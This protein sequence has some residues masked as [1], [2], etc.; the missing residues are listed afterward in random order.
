MENSGK[1]MLESAQGIIKKTAK[2]LHLTKDIVNRLI[3]PNYIHEFE[4]TVK[5]KGRPVIYK[6]FRIQ[7]NNTLG[8]YKGGIR[9]H[10]GVTKEEVQALATLMTIKCAVA[11]IPFGGGKGGVVVDPKKLTESEL[12][13]LSRAYARLIAPFIGPNVDVPAPDV[14]TNSKIMEWMVDE[15]IKTQI[16]NPNDQ[17]K[18]KSKKELE[19]LR[20]TFTGKLVGKGGTL[21]RTEATGRG[22]VIILKALLKKINVGTIF[23]SP[24]KWVNQD[25][26]LQKKIGGLTI[27]VQG[28]GNVGYYFA[29]IASEEGFKVV[30]VSDSHGAVY[31]KGGLSPEKTLQCKK[32]N[33]TVAGCYCKGSV[34]DLRY[35]K[36]ITNE[37]L[38]EL[39]VDVLVPSALENVINGENMRKIKAKIIVEMANGPLTDEAYEFLSKKGVIVVPD[40]LANSGG[41]TVSYLEWFQNMKNEKWSEE[42]VNQRLKK[43]MEKAVEVIWRK[44]EVKRIPLKQAA[45]ELAI[46]RIVKK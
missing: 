35:G 43:M 44:S 8:P 21:G 9:F 33:G 39:P 1:K 38:L 12:E 17:Q 2:N 19:Q 6:G 27:A 7:H 15:Y 10:P 37:A 3:K 23:K 41:V 31:V 13:L 29:K 26:S 34:C 14:N 28:F 45:F 18:P 46:E 22:G 11:G 20:A 4:F 25:S 16:P 5:A 24:E 42:K 32:E 30:A 40:V 36:E